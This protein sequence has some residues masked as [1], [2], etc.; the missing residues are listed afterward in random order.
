MGGV[1]TPLVNSEEI[2]STFCILPW[3]HLSTRPNG[4]M[5]LCCT[6][7]ASSVGEFNDKKHGGEIGIL[8]NEDGRPANFNHTDLKTAWN[9]SYMRTIRKQMLKGEAPALLHEVF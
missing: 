9:S 2:S 5:R 4:H 6:S 7:N 8:K 3:I 1:K